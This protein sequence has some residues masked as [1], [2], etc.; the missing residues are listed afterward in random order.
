MS[1][2]GPLIAKLLLKG[3]SNPAHGV[4]PSVRLCPEIKS[5]ELQGVEERLRRRSKGLDKVSSGPLERS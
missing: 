3:P 1:I 5:Q 2:L 4:R